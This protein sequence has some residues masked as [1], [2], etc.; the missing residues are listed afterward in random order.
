MLSY[1]YR[2]TATLVCAVALAGGCVTHQTVASGETINKLATAEPSVLGSE[3]EFPCDL[4][5]KTEGYECQLRF[6]SEISDKINK[7]GLPD[8][9]HELG[10]HLVE[11]MET[12]GVPKSKAKRLELL[13]GK[14]LLERAKIIVDKT[15]EKPD[16]NKREVPIDSK[17]AVVR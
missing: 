11:L 5:A 1:F 9:C 17:L 8:F 4:T 13:R 14:Y 6:T 3:A 10:S 7:Y 15:E 12:L 2:T 16:D